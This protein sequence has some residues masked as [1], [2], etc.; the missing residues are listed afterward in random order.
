MGIEVSILP[1]AVEAVR[2]RGGLVVA[3]VNPTMPYT[4]GEGELPTDSIDLAVEVDEPLVTHDVPPPDEAEGEI[5]EQTAALVEDGATL[6]LGIG[7]IPDAVAVHLRSRRDL[8]VWS[9]MVSDG[10]LSLERSGALDSDLPLAATFVSGSHDLYRW[11]DCN[12]RIRMRRTEVINDP[13][14]VAAHPGMVSINTAMQ[15]DLFA[16]ANAMFVR[17]RVHSGFGG[18]PDFVAG[19]LHSPGGHAIIALRSWHEKSDA[20]TVVP[21]LPHPVTSFQHSV[22]V[23]EHGR[24]EIFGRSQQTQ[25]R[26]LA[27]RVADPRAR[28]EL[29]ESIARFGELDRAPVE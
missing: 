12:P 22:I 17:R 5:G 19:A 15:V 16:Q 27:D 26:L 3:Q 13:A 9:E 21:L 2:A 18:Q 28:D 11:V 24:A 1:A 10:T 29:R 14:R 23:S 25:A 6:Q 20:S 8:R 4:F 7:A